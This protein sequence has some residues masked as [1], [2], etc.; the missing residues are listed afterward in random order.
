MGVFFFSYRLIL[1]DIL[2]MNWR[3]GQYPGGMKLQ[4]NSRGYLP[5]EKSEDLPGHLSEV[6]VPLSEI[7]MEISSF[8]EL[9]PWCWITCV[10]FQ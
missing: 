1:G 8:C 3:Y 7:G 10:F 5:K 6:L 2:I 9:S 4:G